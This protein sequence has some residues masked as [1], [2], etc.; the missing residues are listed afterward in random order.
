MSN[1]DCGMHI[2]LEKELREAFLQACHA[3]DR[4]AADVLRDFMRDFSEKQQLGKVNIFST[5]RGSL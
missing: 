5:V 3:Q 1:K 4:H 2:R